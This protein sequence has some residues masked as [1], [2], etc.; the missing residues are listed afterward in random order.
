LRRHGRSDLI[1]NGPDQ[2]VPAW[3]SAPVSVKNRFP[4][5]GKPAK[6]KPEYPKQPPRVS[7]RP[8]QGDGRKGQFAGGASHRKGVAVRSGRR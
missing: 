1:G 6:R 3:K 7:Q 4:A 5:P 2:L 8:K